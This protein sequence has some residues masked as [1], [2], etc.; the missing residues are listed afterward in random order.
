MRIGLCIAYSYKSTEITRRRKAKLD[1]NRIRGDRYVSCLGAGRH[2][3]NL[4]QII[5][6][7]QIHT[8]LRLNCSHIVI[9]SSLPSIKFC[10]KL[11][12]GCAPRVS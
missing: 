8:C 10:L 7:T 4:V 3:K 9:A 2:Y 1:F 5:V 6:M 11:F 12:S